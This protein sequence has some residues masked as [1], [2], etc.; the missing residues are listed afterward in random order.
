MSGGEKE[1]I[2]DLRGTEDLLDYATSKGFKSFI[3]EKRVEKPLEDAVLYAYGDQG[4]VHIIEHKDLSQPPEKPFAVW[5]EIKEKAD[6]KKALEAAERGASALFIEAKSW[7]IIPLENIVA[8]LHRRGTKVFVNIWEM[9][10]VETMFNVLE[11]GVDG[12]VYSL[13]ETE[14]IDRAS[15]L[16]SSLKTLW[17][18]LLP[19]RVTEVREVGVGDRV[20]VDT[21]SLLEF[22]EGMLVGSQ[23]NFLFLI[24]SEIIGS[25]FSAPRPFRV[26]AGPIHSYILLPGG[27]TKYLWEME[28]GDRVLIVGGKGKTRVATVG[29]SKIER[30]PLIL[31]KA[32]IDT[33]E[34]KILLQNAE[35]IQLVKKDG[36]PI[37][38]TE[39]KTGDEVMAYVKPT[40]GRH[41]GIEVDEFV[42]EK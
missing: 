31:L 9:G 35:T 8:L 11:L 25:K 2:L 21:T 18:P 4:D 34:G 40:T 5:H 6:E 13:S 10:E 14:D 26:N 1:I 7:R 29:R 15:N 39:V 30:R 23:S 3:V 42:V 36:G 19:V 16:I 37:S 12:V 28:A 22:G 38:V 33:M 41:F 17:L 20:C 27:K 24:H 32:Q